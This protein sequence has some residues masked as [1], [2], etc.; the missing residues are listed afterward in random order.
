MVKLAIYDPATMEGLVDGFVIASADPEHTIYSEC[1]TLE[2]AQRELP[3]LQAE[4]DL[5]DKLQAEYLE[6]EKACLERHGITPERLRV[7]LANAGWWA[8]NEGGQ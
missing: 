4:M 6:W 7:Y 8:S 2:E 3:E 1:D 5:D